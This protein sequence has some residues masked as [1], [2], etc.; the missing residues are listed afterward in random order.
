ME[1]QK[2]TF[3]FKHTL[4][5]ALQ[6]SSSEYWK[7]RLNNNKYAPTP[8][9]HETSTNLPLF[10]DLKQGILYKEVAHNTAQSAHAKF[11]ADLD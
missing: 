7:E 5:K 9:T 3:V 6:K 10:R 1:M 4:T 11:S 2:N 8:Q